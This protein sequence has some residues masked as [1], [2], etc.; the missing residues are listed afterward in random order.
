MTPIIMNCDVLQLTDDQFFE[1]C[2]NN[3]DVRIERNSKG[4]LV[5][6]SPVGGESGNRNARLTQQLLNWSDS[7]KTGIAFDSSTG[8]KLPNNAIRSP[9]ASWIPLTKWN[10]LTSQEKEKFLPLCPDF[11]VELMSPSDSLSNT[12]MKMKEYVENG[13]KLG[14]LINRKTRQV[15]IYRQGKDVEILENPNYLLGEDVLIDFVLDLTV[16]W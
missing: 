2:Q 13:I 16:I 7:N 9:D 11:V 10:Q 8:Y 6:M 12:Q 15:E 5:I 1:L 4:D 3:R 14:W